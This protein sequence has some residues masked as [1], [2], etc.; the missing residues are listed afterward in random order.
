MSGKFKPQ[1]YAF[2]SK[3]AEEAERDGQWLKAKDSW[4]KAVRMARKQ[5]NWLMATARRDFCQR[6]LEQVRE[7]EQLK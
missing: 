2:H 4:T 3:Q 7:Q 5:D 1:T 6:K